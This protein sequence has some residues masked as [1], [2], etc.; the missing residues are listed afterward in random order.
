MFC[1][2]LPQLQ[3][4]RP[5]AG[6]RPPATAGPRRLCCRAAP[7]T[8]QSAAPGSSFA[9]RAVRP[10][11]VEVRV[12][13]LGQRSR[14]ASTICPC[15]NRHAGHHA[16]ERRENLTPLGRLQLAAGRHLK[17]G[18]HR[19]QR[20]DSADQHDHGHSV[21][22]SAR[23]RNSH[24]TWPIAFHTGS[25]NRLLCSIAF[26]SAPHC[27][28]PQSPPASAASR[29]PAHRA[30]APRSAPRSA[31]V[32]IPSA[33]FCIGRFNIRSTSRERQHRH[34]PRMRPIDVLL[35]RLLNLRRQLLLPRLAPQRLARAQHSRGQLA[36]APAPRPPG[37]RSN[38]GR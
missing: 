19:R 24:V 33:A 32:A 1:G 35:Q 17:I 12:R 14:P 11:A 4:L 28:E 25:K 34:Q 13:Q 8:A 15:S 2:F 9:G 16:V 30:I 26:A 23:P 18:R 10:A 7:A 38:P 5:P 20:I 6:S 37:D 29:S 36:P 31:S 3:H 22:G 21:F 27:D